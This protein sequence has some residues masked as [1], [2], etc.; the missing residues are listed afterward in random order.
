[1]KE[2]IKKRQKVTSDKLMHLQLLKRVI[3]GVFN[4]TAVL[5]QI[6]CLLK[7]A[8]GLFLSMSL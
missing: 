1:M 5:L 8:A 4:L 2:A 3:I 6:Q 7:F